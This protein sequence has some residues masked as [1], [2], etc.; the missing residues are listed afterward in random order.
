MTTGS[1]PTTSVKTD[2]FDLVAS[3]TCQSMPA[4]PLTVYH[5]TGAFVSNRVVICGGT[6]PS[7]TSQCYSL[8]KN[9]TEWKPSGNLITPRYGAASVEM[10]GKLL[11]FGGYNAGYLQSTE[12]MDVEAGTTTIG[13]SMPLAIGYPCTVKINSST[14]LIIGGIG[15]SYLKST[16]FYSNNEK[17]FKAGPYLMVPRSYHTCNI[18]SNGNGSYVVVTGGYDNGVYTDS[19]EYLDL[20]EPTIW[21][22][23]M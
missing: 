2:S 23:G 18:L 20:D 4:Y 17:T 3:T 12:E 7:V 15:S 10:H 22:T 6:Y 8:G 13:P 16:Y 21:K 11:I 14:V 19:T 9:E 1:P 5:A